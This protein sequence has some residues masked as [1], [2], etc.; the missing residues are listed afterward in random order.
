[1]F[2]EKTVILIIFCGSAISTMQT[3]KKSVWKFIVQNIFWHNLW[4][5]FYGEGSRVGK[6]LWNG[7]MKYTFQYIA[8]PILRFIPCLDNLWAYE[9]FKQVFFISG[10]CACLKHIAKHKKASEIYN[11]I[12]LRLINFFSMGKF[13][14]ANRRSRAS[15]LFM[16]RYFFSCLVEDWKSI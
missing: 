13:N 7:N 15:K 5:R 16:F 3:R 14:F 1:M 12:S 2:N 4:A 8:T 9:K 11:P 6:L 10:V